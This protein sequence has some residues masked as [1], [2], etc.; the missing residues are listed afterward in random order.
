MRCPRIVMGLIL[1]LSSA[2]SG[3]AFKL[4]CRIEGPKQRIP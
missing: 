2:A 3:Q 1:V 4:V